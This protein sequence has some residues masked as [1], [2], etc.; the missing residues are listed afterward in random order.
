[1]IS[2]FLYRGRKR[3]TRVDRDRELIFQVSSILKAA[4]KDRKMVVD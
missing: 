1:V 2:E 3:L 4:A